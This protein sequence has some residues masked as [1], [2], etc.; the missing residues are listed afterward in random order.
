MMPTKPKQL[1]DDEPETS[2]L[3]GAWQTW[4]A[5]PQDPEAHAALLKEMSPVIDR[6]AATH[7]KDVNPL[8]RSRARRMALDAAATYDPKKNAS[9]ETH[10]FGHLKGLKRYAAKTAQMI[11]VPERV[12]LDRR[13]VTAASTELQEDLGRDPT[14]DEL[15]DRT[16]IPTKRLKYIRTF[17][18]SVNEGRYEAIGEQDENGGG[19]MPAVQGPGSEAWLHVIY[20]ELPPLDKKI[21]EHTL[22]W[23]GHP[24][25]SNQD[26]A[27][28]LRRSPGYVSQRKL[29]IQQMLDKETALSPFGT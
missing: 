19:Y 11:S 7:V 15:A 26:I 3:A 4:K 2:S 5:S 9:L 20:D 22:G 12:L 10:L 21:F 27:A 6:A 23:N 17:H 18:P 28:R 16:G 29:A 14:D 1:L 8:I 24:K 25:L 13:T